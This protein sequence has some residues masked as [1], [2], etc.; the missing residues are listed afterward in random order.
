[1]ASGSRSMGSTR[2][3]ANPTKPFLGSMCSIQTHTGSGFS[4]C[5][6]LLVNRSS[7]QKKPGAPHH[8]RTG[9][10]PAPFSIPVEDGQVEPSIPVR[11]KSLH[12]RNDG[13]QAGSPKKDQ[14]FKKIR[15]LFLPCGPA[16]TCNHWAEEACDTKKTIQ[17]CL[18]MRRWIIQPQKTGTQ[19]QSRRHGGKPPFFQPCGEHKDPHRPIPAA[20]REG[21]EY[22]AG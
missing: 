9:K 19:G 7:H 22:A 21:E 4:S 14:L 2:L 20:K 1:M 6:R 8:T 13:Q 12:P 11:P 5:I 15:G 3:G 10:P 17:D 16:G 18:N